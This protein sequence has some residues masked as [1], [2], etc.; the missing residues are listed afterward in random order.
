MTDIDSQTSNISDKNNNKTDAI[1]KKELSEIE[2]ASLDSNTLIAQTAT[3]MQ[4]QTRMRLQQIKRKHK[5]KTK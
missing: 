1:I 2:S 3:M 4:L 5:T